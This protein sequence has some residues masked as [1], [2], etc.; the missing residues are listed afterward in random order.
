[1]LAS[2]GN[3]SGFQGDSLRLRR[4]R[5]VPGS[6]TGVFSSTNSLPTSL[7]SVLG[8]GSQPGRLASHRALQLWEQLLQA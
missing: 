4:S 7:A 2:W 1:M 8:A 3:C 6:A 5:V